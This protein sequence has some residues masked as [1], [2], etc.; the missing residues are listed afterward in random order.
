[1]P[2]FFTDLNPW[3]PD[4]PKI[5]TS[6]TGGTES[7]CQVPTVLGPRK[8][9]LAP[10]PYFWGANI[11]HLNDGYFSWIMATFLSAKKC[12]ENHQKSRKFL[13]Q[14][15][16]ENGFRNRQARLT[17]TTKEWLLD[18][19]RHSRTQGSKVPT[20]RFCRGPVLPGGP[21]TWKTHLN[22]EDTVTPMNY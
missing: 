8:V 2:F 11:D 18:T 16:P 20:P 7:F 9:C 5:E 21:L 1:M 6:D 14:E 15:T 17:S 13:I 4:G 3:E 10:I 19:T 12:Q 22:L